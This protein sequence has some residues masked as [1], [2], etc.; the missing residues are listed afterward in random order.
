[1]LES[2]TLDMRG[3]V[4]GTALLKVDCC[5][6][7]DA[8]GCYLSG[9]FCGASSPSRTADLDAVFNGPGINYR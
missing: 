9:V 8:L 1:M 6:V 5:Y 7:G 2:S 4:D 3:V